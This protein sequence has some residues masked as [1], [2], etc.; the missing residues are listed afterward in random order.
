MPLT[1]IPRHAFTITTTAGASVGSHN[2]LNPD[3]SSGNFK[4]VAENSSNAA[5]NIFTSSAATYVGQFINV[6]PFGRLRIVDKVSNSTL[7]VYAEVPLFNGDNIDDGDWELETGYE[8]TWSNTRGWP[9]SATF[10]EG[11]LYFGG[12]KSR[13]NTIWGSKVVDYFNFDIGTALDDESVEATINTSQL[14]SI[15]FLLLKIK[16]KKK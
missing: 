16:F 15:H 5:V 8:N 11:R 14:N 13:P 1:N 6:E 2:H 3:G 4:I 9:K 7:K 12:A 10:H